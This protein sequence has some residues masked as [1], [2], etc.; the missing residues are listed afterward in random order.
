MQFIAASATVTATVVGTP[1]ATQITAKVPAGLVPAGSTSAQVKIT[2]TTP[3]EGGS[4]ILS[5]DTFVVAIPAP[6]FDSP[7]FSKNSGVGNDQITLNGQNFNFGPVTVKFDTANATIVG[8]PTST[9][10]AVLVP[11]GMTPPGTPKKVKITVSTAGGSVT[12]SDA[13]PFTVNG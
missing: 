4:S 5:D 12:T 3:A 10:I 13:L 1:T 9:Q 11:T 6:T 7:P 8:T 2:V